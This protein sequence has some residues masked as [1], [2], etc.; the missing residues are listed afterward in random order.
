M[1]HGRLPNKVNV[2]P[3]SSMFSPVSVNTLTFCQ[4]VFVKMIMVYRIES[5]F[6]AVI[7][8][9]KLRALA[10]SRDVGVG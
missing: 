1:L 4:T 10:E 9:N 6:E 3:C 5:Y 7:S 2:W 8:A